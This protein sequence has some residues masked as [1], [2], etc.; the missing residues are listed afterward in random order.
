MAPWEVNETTSPSTVL[1]TGNAATK[2]M[3]VNGSF[4]AGGG[5]DRFLR[6][7]APSCSC[8]V[9]AGVFALPLGASFFALA[10]F[11]GGAFF[12][13]TCFFDGPR[14]FSGVGG[15]KASSTASS[16]A[17]ET[18]GSTLA[19]P[20]GGLFGLIGHEGS[21]VAAATLDAFFDLP[22][23]LAAFLAARANSAALA[24]ADAWSSL[25]F[26]SAVAA[27]LLGPRIG[28]RGVKIQPTPG[29]GLPPISRPSSKSQGCS[30]WNSWKESLDRT[31]APVRSAIR[32]TNASP[33]PMAPAGG[34]MTSPL[35]MASRTSSRSA[36][37]TRCS[38]V[39]S[40]TTMMLA[41]GSSEAYARTASSSCSRLGNVRPS[42]ARLDPSTTTWCVSANGTSQQVG[43]LQ[44]VQGGAPDGRARRFGSA[45]VAEP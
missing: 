29:T 7:L 37:P 1:P 5:A 28:I 39:A 31:V 40:T 41:S 44:L 35:S 10:L 21:T 12:A 17:L 19:R 33:R 9:R 6:W 4:T 18:T 42:V 30:P 22:A 16:I 45:D 24:G 13:A 20:G 23:R 25:A 27:L 2:L 32:N 14:G 11:C 3:K 26:A 15:C 8:S 34:E 38:K 43:L 36:S